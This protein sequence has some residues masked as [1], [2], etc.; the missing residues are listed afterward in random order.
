VP[1]K[2]NRRKEN[3]FTYLATLGIHHT[4]ILMI[5]QDSKEF[6]IRA[7]RNTLLEKKT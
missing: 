7:H 1:C 4:T 5:S 2:S 3:P 6:P